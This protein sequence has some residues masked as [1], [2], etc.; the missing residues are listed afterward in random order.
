MQLQVFG[1]FF[2]EKGR[3]K[4]KRTAHSLNYDLIVFGGLHSV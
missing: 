3:N 4:M 1:K 2:P